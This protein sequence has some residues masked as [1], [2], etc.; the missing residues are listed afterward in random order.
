M[1]KMPPSHIMW[2][3]HLQWHN[4]EQHS[5]LCSSPFLSLDG[6]KGCGNFGKDDGKEKT[7]KIINPACRNTPSPA[8]SKTSFKWHFFPRMGSW[9]AVL[10]E[11]ALA[12]SSVFIILWLSYTKVIDFVKK[13]LTHRKFWWHIEGNRLSFHPY[14]LVSHDVWSPC[15]LGVYSK[16]VQNV[17]QDIGN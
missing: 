3:A 7:N 5:V 10:A 12:V 15:A 8:T 14:R 16:D 13:P 2:G 1:P 6:R 17:K 11:N 4:G 9:E